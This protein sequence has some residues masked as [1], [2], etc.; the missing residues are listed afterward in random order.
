MKRNDPNFK[1]QFIILHDN[2]GEIIVRKKDIF[3]VAFFKEK[4][5]IDESTTYRAAICIGSISRMLLVKESVD[6]ILELL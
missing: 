4:G 1:E 5:N 6:E 2:E 3:A